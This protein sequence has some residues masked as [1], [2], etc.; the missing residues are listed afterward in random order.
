M[1]C[2]HLAG[3]DACR[4]LLTRYLVLRR[5]LS[6]AFFLG[7]VLDIQAFTAS[8]V[9]LL[10]SQNKTTA[11]SPYAESGGPSNVETI[12]ARTVTLMEEKSNNAT[13]AAKFGAY[14][15]HTIRSLSQLLSTAPDDTLAQQ[16]LTLKVPLL[17]KL[18]VRRR[19]LESSPRSLSQT[20]PEI[21]RNPLQPEL[22]DDLDQ[23]QQRAEPGMQT[24][25]SLMSALSLRDLS[26][27]LYAPFSWY[28][29]NNYDNSFQD[30]LMA[31]V[32]LGGWDIPN[33]EDGVLRR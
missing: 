18:Q 4:T 16:E 32:E 3:I 28:V 9:L 23:Y 21:V 10:T 11:A 33:F 31:D 1:R 19:P 7:R 22:P 2:S 6:A 29:V 13:S 20:T 5:S 15:A 26:N 12:V 17:G 30:A 27:D 8:V 25:A 24:H 14:G